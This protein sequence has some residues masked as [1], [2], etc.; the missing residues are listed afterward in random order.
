MYFWHLI[1]IQF[2]NALRWRNLSDFSC[3]VLDNFFLFRLFFHLSMHMLRHNDV[4]ILTFDRQSFLNGHLCMENVLIFVRT[5]Y[6][7]LLSLLA[8]RFVWTQLLIVC[9]LLN[10]YF[11][12]VT[13][14][15]MV[16]PPVP[17]P[18][19]STFYQGF[20]HNL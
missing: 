5:V 1:H 14:Q 12:S 15:N 13:T 20:Q 18:I 17:S 10:F 2:L 8:L 4:P 19:H 7:T 6:P 9:V 16:T 11:V 3:N